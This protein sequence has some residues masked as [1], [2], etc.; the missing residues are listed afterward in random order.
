MGGGSN[1]TI[2]CTP[3]NSRMWVLFVLFLAEMA[4][5]IYHRSKLSVQFAQSYTLVFTNLSCA[6][7]RTIRKVKLCECYHANTSTTKR[8]LTGGSLTA[9]G[10][11]P[12]AELISRKLSVKSGEHTECVCL[13]LL[14]GSEDM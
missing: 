4:P 13:Y 2:T 1:H 6:P 12:S 11:A 5:E 9:H 14:S 3:E 10:S 7:Q 8:V